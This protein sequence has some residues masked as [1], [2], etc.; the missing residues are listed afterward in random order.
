MSGGTEDPLLDEKR[1]RVIKQA[2]ATHSGIHRGLLM[3]TAKVPRL[4]D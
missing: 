3:L 2:I 1:S 4:K